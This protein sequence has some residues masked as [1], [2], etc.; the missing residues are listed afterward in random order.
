MIGGTSRA[1]FV[2]A[3]GKSS[4]MGENKAFLVYSGRPLIARIAEAVSAAAGQVALVGD[5]EV[6]GRLGYPAIPDRFVNCGPLGGMAA[7]LAYT[8]ADWNLLVACDMPAVT[9]GL[10]S[11]I[12][13]AAENLPG[14]ADCLV[15]DAPPGGLQPLCAVYRRRCCGPAQDALARGERK[16]HDWLH[17]LH[18]HRWPVGEAS[19]FQNVNTPLEWNGFLQSHSA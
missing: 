11:A 13:E 8:T 9:T 12:L 10:L 4:R 17:T 2:L 14:E 15:P 16:V 5:P 19:P 18:V 3:G 1:G 6:Y 7:A